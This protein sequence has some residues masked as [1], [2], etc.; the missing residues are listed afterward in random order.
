MPR[1]QK[2]L[3]KQNLSNQTHRFIDVPVV[4]TLSWICGSCAG[5]AKEK[6]ITRSEVAIDQG[7]SCE[8]LSLKNVCCTGILSRKDAGVGKQKIEN[9]EN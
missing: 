5:H 4:D 8:F 9:R 1:L 3:L 7:R 6:K 2:K